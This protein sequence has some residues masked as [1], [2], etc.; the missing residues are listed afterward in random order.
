MAPAV[1]TITLLPVIVHIG[2]LVTVRDATG[3]PVGTRFDRVGAP[4]LEFVPV[5]SAWSARPT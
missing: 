1:V 2:V 3:A 4:I 5:P